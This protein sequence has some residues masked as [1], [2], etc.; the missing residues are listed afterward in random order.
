MKSTQPNRFPERLPIDPLRPDLLAALG[1]GPVVVSSPT[2]SGKSTQVPRWC[3]G[4]TL[5]VE[6]RRV[7]CRSLAQRVAELEGTKLGEAV[8][9]QVR[10]EKRLSSQT[11]ILFATP[12]IVLRRFAELLEAVDT[13]IL[14]EFHER[15]LDVDLLLALVRRRFDGRLIIM[16]ATLD[17]DAVAREL[18][19]RHLHA[20]GRLHPVDVRYLESG[21]L[22]PDVRG[23]EGRVARAVKE[24]REVPGDVLV[25]LPGKAEIAAC[26]AA[27]GGSDA[28]ILEL[29]GGLSLEKQ[30]RAFAPATRR[31]V[32]LAT[33]VAETSITLPG[34]GVVVDSGLVRRTRYHQGR[35][36]LTLRPIARDS[37][38]Q[39]VGRAGRTGPGMARRLWQ[40]AGILEERTPPEIHRES[41]VPLLLGAA[42][43]GARLE[44]LDFLDP[45]REHAVEQAREDLQALDALDD[46]DRLTASG[47][48]LFGLP[49]DAPLGRWLVEA[50]G[51]DT[52]SPGVLDDMIDLVATLAGGRPLWSSPPRDEHDLSD[53]QS[54]D[55]T[56]LVRA[57]RGVLPEDSAAVQPAALR[58]AR[59]VRRQLRRAFKRRG[60]P[61]AKPEIDRRRLALTILAADPRTAH[62]ARRRGRRVAF[63]NGGT[64]IGLGRSSAAARLEEIEALVALETRDLGHGRDA[65]T[66]VTRALPVP[67]AWLVGAGLG[68]ERVA[69][70]G[71]DRGRVVAR[72]ERVFAKRVLDTREEVPRGEHARGAIVRLFLD[73]RIFRDSLEETRERLRLAGLARQVIDRRRDGND[74]L[75]AD[76]VRQ[77]FPGEVPELAAW[78]ARRVDELGVESGEDLALL[79]DEDFLAPELPEWVREAIESEYPSVLEVAGAAFEIEYD[80][81]RREAVMRQVRGTPHQIP[82][83]FTLP[84]LPGLTLRLEHRG[85]LKT[86]VDRRL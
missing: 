38:D 58:E 43:C 7:A 10:D 70:P 48:E 20:E 65:R 32:I 63:S 82:P 11:R 59:S 68:R 47:Q 30:G 74:V 8:G 19:G 27:L 76:E 46:N 45:P 41:L 26:A 49:L 24:T 55:A 84:R 85:T 37:A 67:T 34:V 61:P 6:P 29:H 57:L 28:E 44:E 25:F 17:G 42:A 62:L 64:E 79:T 23:L 72:I 75:W 35:G 80:L 12:G 83:E 18:D 52:K 39:R 9:Y 73:G 31:K 21:P 14:D 77:R 40:E 56:L 86:L 5:V 81:P 69:A 22:L 53:A 54:C 71:I 50:R 16:S 33:N 2:G 3:P 1:E 66:L 78:T 13:I 51:C 15:R 4:T 60:E 36:F